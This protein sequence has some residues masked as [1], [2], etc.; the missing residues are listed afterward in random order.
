MRLKKLCLAASMHQVNAWAF[1]STVKALELCN[2]SHLLSMY[3][4][5]VSP[6]HAAEQYR[7]SSARV[8]LMQNY[9]TSDS[10]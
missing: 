3:T 10:E 1:M 4:S 8:Y 5:R 2:L 7:N 9:A 6:P